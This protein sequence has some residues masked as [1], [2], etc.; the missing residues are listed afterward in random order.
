MN[1]N[2]WHENAQH[3]FLGENDYDFDPKKDALNLAKHKISLRNC[4]YFDWSDSL[5]DLSNNL[6]ISE[7]RFVA[8]GYIGN[9]LHVM[10]YCIRSGIV[11]VISLRKAN[12]REVKYYAETPSRHHHPLR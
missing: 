11:R 8:Y 10:V 7:S 6:A 2:A 12:K 5:I 3:H 1:N 9:R 4:L